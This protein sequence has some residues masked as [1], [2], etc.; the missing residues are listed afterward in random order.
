MTATAMVRPT[1][2]PARSQ[3]G[4]VRRTV[5]SGAREDRLFFAQVREDPLLEIAALAPLSSAR[6]VV[7]SSGGCTAFSLLAAG[8]REVVAVDLNSTQNHLVELKSVAL[9]RLLTPELMSFFGVAPGTAHRRARTYDVL[10][11]HL[12]SGAA[13]FWDN[14]LSLIARGVLACGVSERFIAAVVGVVK[15]GIHGRERIERLLSLESLEEQRTFFAAEWN[16]R[17][18]KLLFPL[19]L[20]RWTFNRAYDPA[21]FRGVENPGFAAHFRGLLEH[22]LCEVPVRTNYFLHQMLTGKYPTHAAGGVP[23]YL[24]RGRREFLRSRLDSVELVDGGYAEYLRTCEDESVDAFAL[25]NICEWLDSAG[26][27]EL[28]AQVVRVARP[29]ARVCFRNF[30]GHTTVPES[31]RTVIVEDISRSRAAIQRDRSCMQSRIA[32]CRVEK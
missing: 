4:A 31:F 20:N 14:N 26:I 19:L 30:V 13:V 25:S 18:W 1:E 7:V 15:L 24:D 32:I 28:F 9:R 17:R 12:S 27:D 22:A 2:P 16:T 6:V 5:M 11:P 8:A 23:P 29:G 3:S 21:F 10:R